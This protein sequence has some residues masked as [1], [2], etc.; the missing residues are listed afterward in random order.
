MAP[1]VAADL[2]LGLFPKPMLSMIEPT[3]TATMQHVGVS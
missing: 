1:L 2:V 3:V